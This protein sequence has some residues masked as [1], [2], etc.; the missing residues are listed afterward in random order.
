MRYV[1]RWE[2]HAPN[3]MSNHGVWDAVAGDWVAQGLSHQAASWHAAILTLRYDE[4]GERP[5][6]RAWYRDPPQHAELHITPRR[7]E[8]VLLHLWVRESDGLHGYV[9]YLERDS[10]DAGRWAEAARLRKL[11]VSEIAAF[12]DRHAQRARSFGLPA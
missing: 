10:R 4:D 1:D 3:P 6:D 11:T 7:T 9:T 8:V 2:L 5:E 12:Q